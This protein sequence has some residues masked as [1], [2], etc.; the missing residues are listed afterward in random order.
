V[1]TNNGAQVWASSLAMVGVAVLTV[2]TSAGLAWGAGGDLV[3]S[4]RLD[5]GRFH[6]SAEAIA[7]N[8][9]RVFVAGAAGGLTNTDFLVRAYDAGTGALL[10]DNR[11]D[12]GGSE[13]AIAVTTVGTKVFAAGPSFKSAL[14]VRGVVR[15]YDAGSG[16]IRWEDVADAVYF[17]AIAAY[18]PRVFVGGSRTGT[19][20]LGP[21]YIRAYG[22]ATG[23]VLW[24]DT[25]GTSAAVQALSASGPS[26]FVTA[27]VHDDRDTGFGFLVR[28]Y[29]AQTGQLRWE[30]RDDGYAAAIT[31][32]GTRVIVAGS[33]WNTRGDDNPLF[34]YDPVVRAY[35]AASGNIL[36][37]NRQPAGDFGGQLGAVAVRN[38]WVVAAGLVANAVTGADILV[39][40]YDV[41]RG[42][43][44][45]EDQHDGGAGGEDMTIVTSLSIAGDRVA[46]AGS[47][48]TGVDDQ[49]FDQFFVRAYELDS[50]LPVWED[51]QGG[52][53][54][55]WAPGVVA[56]GNRFFTAGVLTG[57]GDFDFVVRAYEAR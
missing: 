41:R 15:A 12:A 4:D 40:A 52:G 50:G 8:A 55:D 44:L 42:A 30:S 9:N 39:R 49:F 32:Q 7:A 57:P 3:W 47:V 13:S 11:E 48:S 43:L 24:E 31:T 38:G 56:L 25:I 6:D 28:A 27:V 37:E 18:G 33:L 35:D 20:E 36:W 23:E 21:G 53:D 19:S 5:T 45:W 51:T 46:V 2:V 16:V 29:D 10:W 34:P 26:V 54:N 17:R 14:D 22:A 1:S